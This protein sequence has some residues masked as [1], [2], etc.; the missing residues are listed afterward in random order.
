MVWMGKGLGWL[1]K[2]AVLILLVLAVGYILRLQV[3]IGG[4][5]SGAVSRGGFAG[6]DVA[7]MPSGGFTNLGVNKTMQPIREVA[8]VARADRLV[9]R[10]TGLS[11]QVKDV[12]LSINRIEAIARAK[13]GFLV[14]SNLT[15]P[16]GAANGSIAVRVP[17]DKRLETME[18]F[19]G[20]AVKVVSESVV[21]TDV[22]DQFVDN[23]ARLDVLNK[24]KAKFEEILGRAD[25]VQDLLQVQREL[26][27]IQ[28]QIDNVRGQQKYL[29]QTAKLTKITVYLST[30]ELALPYAP[31]RSW[32]PGV[33]FKRAVRSLVGTLRGVGS[34]VI[35]VAVYTPILIPVG[36]V[37]WWAKKRGTTGK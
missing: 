1:K 23:E 33:V 2:N 36:L 14:D 3:G 11:L 20:L 5:G 13:G 30:D 12:G 29:E 37:W 34:G 16:E 25:Q 27:N 28:Q 24:T 17:E 4:L 9:V 10:D 18:E 21:G 15:R 7:M 26:I 6:E 19:K 35:W 32:R 8:P 22:T 31:D